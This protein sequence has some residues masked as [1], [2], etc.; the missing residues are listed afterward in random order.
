VSQLHDCLIVGGGAAGLSASLVLG[1]ARRDALLVDA[2]AQSNRPAHAVGGLLAQEGTS[3]AALYEAG[4]AQLAGYPSVTTRR[5]RV[6]AIE[7]REDGTFAARLADGDSVAARRVLLATGME[8]VPPDLP[9]VAE[10]WGDTVFHC[11]FCHGWEVRDGALAALGDGEVGVTKALLLRGWSDE[12]VLLG[13]GLDPDGR[14]KLESANVTVDERPVTAIAGE[15][16]TVVF[17]DG[18]E[19]PRDGVLV[20][21]P[22]RQRSDLV[23][24]LGLDLSEN[25]TVAVNGFGETSVSGLFAAGDVAGTPAMVASAIGAG[26]STAAFLRHSLLAEDHDLPVPPAARRAEAPR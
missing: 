6:T 15:R 8:Y 13:T 22:P 21:A 1:R 10:R 26:A 14:A 23:Q 16:A 25:G 24:R 7:R 12:V 5:D 17:A 19:L 20:G 9:G 18:G 4:S 11:P 3:P 2:G